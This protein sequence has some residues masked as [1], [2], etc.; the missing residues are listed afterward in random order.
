MGEGEE[1]KIGS[2][3]PKSYVITAAQAIQSERHAKFYGP[4]RTKGV[5]NVSLIKEAAL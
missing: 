2:K 5:P 3:Y 4:D 1:E